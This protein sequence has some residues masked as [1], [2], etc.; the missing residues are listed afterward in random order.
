MKQGQILNKEWKLLHGSDIVRSKILMK[1]GGIYID[2][3]VFVL[4][5]MQKFRK[6]EFALGWP[7]NE[8]LGTQVI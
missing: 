5:S 8:T 3:D 4:R 1:Y 6:F 2:S 7:K